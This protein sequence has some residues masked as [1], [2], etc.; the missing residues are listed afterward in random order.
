MLCVVRVDPYT[1]RGLQD[2]RDGRHD[3][4]QRAGLMNRR[5][6]PPLS[7]GVGGELLKVLVEFCQNGTVS[8]QEKQSGGW[9]SR[10]RQLRG[11]GENDQD[12]FMK[13]PVSKKVK[14]PA[15][16]GMI[17]R[18]CKVKGWARR[19]V[20]PWFSFTIVGRYWT[21]TDKKVM[22]QHHTVTC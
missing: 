21:L 15:P 5:R 7:E 4:G 19:S 16:A 1:G 6:C 8:L 20:S 18:R 17:S 11:G 14:T 13:A 9:A 3:G 22:R 12:F 10:L 2:E